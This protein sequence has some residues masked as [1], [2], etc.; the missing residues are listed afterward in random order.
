MESAHEEI[1]KNRKITIEYDRD[2][3]NPLTEWDMLGTFS[4]FHRNYNLSTPDAIKDIDELKELI[5]R[6]D[7]LA[8]PLFLYDH[9]GITISTGPF[10]CPWDSGQVGC[11]HITHEKI[12]AEYGNTDPET[13]KK[14]TG[15]LK[16]EVKT[17][18]AYLTGDVYG[19]IVDGKPEPGEDRDTAEEHVDSCWGYYGPGYQDALN[20]A[21]ASINWNAK[22]A[23]EK[24]LAAIA[25]AHMIPAAQALQRLDWIHHRV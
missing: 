25:A 3:M 7:V 24:R 2:A 12:K 10:P 18:D 14:V 20:G 19:W 15:Y 6:P 11:I 21:K 1:Y 17:F 4:C 22:R 9:S 16:G 13:I 8:L 23:E 5:E